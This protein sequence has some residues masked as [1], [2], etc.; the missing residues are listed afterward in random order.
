MPS[1]RAAPTTGTAACITFTATTSWPVTATTACP[2]PSLRRLFSRSRPRA[3]RWA[4]R[5]SKTSSFCLAVMKNS[6]ARAIRLRLAPWG[7]PPSTW[8]SRQQPSQAPSALPRAPTTLT[9]VASTLRVLKRWSRTRCSSSTGTSVTSTV[10]A[11]AMPRRKR[12]TRSSRTS[13]PASWH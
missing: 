3:L 4:A 9:L 12:A 13:P 7:T 8:P 5:S 10:P 6:A 2:T 1:P 11:C